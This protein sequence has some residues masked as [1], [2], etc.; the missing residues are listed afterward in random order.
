MMVVEVLEENINQFLLDLVGTP[1]VIEQHGPTQPPGC[2]SLSADLSEEFK[3]QQEL[4]SRP[5]GSNRHM[6]P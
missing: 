2:T 1:F 6:K 3:I 4:L 5:G